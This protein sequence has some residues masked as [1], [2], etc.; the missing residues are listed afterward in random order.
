MAKITNRTKFTLAVLGVMA[1]QPY[2]KTIAPDKTETVPDAVAK[3]WSELDVVKAHGKDVE[4]KLDGTPA[5]GEPAAADEPKLLWH[6]AVK[7]VE[8]M[9]DKD[10]LERM[11]AEETRSS[12]KVA[13]E[14]RFEALSA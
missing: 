7:M 12:V 4:V 14:K 8:S 10:E 3:A 11:H 5:E 2:S 6:Q 9:T 13:I 1:C